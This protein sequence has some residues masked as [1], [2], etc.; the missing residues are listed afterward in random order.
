MWFQWLLNILSFCFLVLNA[1]GIDT[2]VLELLTILEN[3]FESIWLQLLG[4][5]KWVNGALKNAP[6]PIDFKVLGNTNEVILV[7]LNAHSTI[8][9]NELPRVNEFRYELVNALLPIVTT[10]SGISK[11]VNL[12]KWECSEDQ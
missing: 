6:V 4:I 5:S 7:S 10:L 1:E 9:S 11:L 12:E 8:V 3:A 2:V